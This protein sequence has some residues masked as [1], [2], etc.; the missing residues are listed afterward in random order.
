MLRPM[1]GW[2]WPPRGRVADAAI[3]VV[4][5]V[6]V[7][8]GTQLGVHGSTDGGGLDLVGALLILLACGLLYLRRR[9]P[10]LVAIT[11]L[12]VCTTYYIVSDADGPAVLSFVVALYTVATERQLIVAVTISLL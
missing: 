3:V 7:L 2:V 11:T 6:I 8:A 9:F 1:S 4:V 12:A 10:V 5:A